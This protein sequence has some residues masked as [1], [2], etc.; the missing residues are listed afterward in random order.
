M[1]TFAWR[2]A[3]RSSNAE[4]AW[5]A[6]PACVVGFSTL[7]TGALTVAK[8]LVFVGGLGGRT[9]EPQGRAGTRDAASSV[10]SVLPVRTRRCVL[11]SH[12]PSHPCDERL[13]PPRPRPGTT[14][15]SAII[16]RSVVPRL[17]RH[18]RP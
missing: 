2:E 1:P 7:A 3:I 6:E 16:G 15:R 5:A 12:A 4:A 8:G 13:V 9:A 17:A 14:V 11:A 10:A 18:P